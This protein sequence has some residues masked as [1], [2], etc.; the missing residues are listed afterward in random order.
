M[1]FIDDLD[2][3]PV[4]RIVKVLETIKL[5]MDKKGCIFV[6]G[7]AN[8]IIIKA[9]KETYKEDA[10]KFMAKIVQV[11]FNLPQIPEGDFKISQGLERRIREAL[12]AGFEPAALGLGIPSSIL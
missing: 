11:T 1:I 2:R 10:E 12:L 8:K 3:C 4:P 6:I 5:F 7:A 9:L